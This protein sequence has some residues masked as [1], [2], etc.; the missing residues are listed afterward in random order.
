MLER[1][2]AHG[3]ADSAAFTWNKRPNGHVRLPGNPLKSY[4]MHLVASQSI[5]L[6]GHHANPMLGES[7]G[8]QR[9]SHR[10][11]LS[12]GVNPHANTIDYCP[13]SPRKMCSDVFIKFS[14]SV[15]NH[16]ALSSPS[17]YPAVTISSEI[18]IDMGYSFLCR[19]PKCLWRWNF[20]LT[21]NTYSSH[22]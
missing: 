11:D 6:W 3:F 20:N 14:F 7:G 2:I 4:D 1:V 9:K 16:L 19:C 10:R 8:G 5:Y 17:L 13:L 12:W 22:H 21:I 15:C 18:R